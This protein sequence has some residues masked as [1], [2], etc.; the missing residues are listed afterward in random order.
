MPVN[1]FD[2]LIFSSPIDSSPPAVAIRL[3]SLYFYR[4]P[5]YI[6]AMSAGNGSFF[7]YFKAQHA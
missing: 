1:S 3:P 4:W 7:S 5:P 2:T 6:T